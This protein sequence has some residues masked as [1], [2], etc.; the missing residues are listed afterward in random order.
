MEYAGES[1][2][3][4]VARVRLYRRTKEALVHRGVKPADARVIFLPGPE[5]SEV[6]ALA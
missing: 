6:G 3:K 5:A 1:L 2:A 4:K